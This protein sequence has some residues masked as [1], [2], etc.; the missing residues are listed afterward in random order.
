MGFFSDSDGDSGGGSSF[1]GGGSSVGSV[2]SQGSSDEG[3]DFESMMKAWGLNQDPK[4]DKKKKEEKKKQPWYKF[5]LSRNKN[6][7]DDSDDGIPGGGKRKS[8]GRDGKGD[9][10]PSNAWFV[11][12]FGSSGRKTAQKDL[13]AIDDG[14]D[15]GT[16]P[17]RARS[18]GSIKVSKKKSSKRS[19]ARD[20]SSSPDYDKMWFPGDKEAEA[21]GGT[22]MLGDYDGLGAMVPFFIRNF[23]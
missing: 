21:P 10:K 7:D 20:R 23:S 2:N 5:G 6:K 11:N 22:S 13:I 12:P 14:E 8:K 1:G 4:K 19:S 9:R 17:K 15:L 3:S 18:K 16:R